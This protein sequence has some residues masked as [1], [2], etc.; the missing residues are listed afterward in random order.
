MADR[1]SPD[2]E[3]PNPWTQALKM[4]H[5]PARYLL[6]GLLAAK[7]GNLAV[8]GDDDQSIHSFPSAAT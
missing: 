2:D 4:G 5:G 6:C 1:L 8:V 7:H 3:R